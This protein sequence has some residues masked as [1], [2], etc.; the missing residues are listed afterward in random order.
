MIHGGGSGGRRWRVPGAGCVALCALLLAQVAEA[1]S[2]G[3]VDYA[4]TKTVA[5][6]NLVLNGMG[7]REATML[8]VDVYVAG[9]YLEKRS[10]DG[11]AIARSDQVKQMVLKLVRDVDAKDMNEAIEAGFKKNAGNNVAKLAPRVEKF[12]KMMPDLH[13]GD[14]VEFTSVPG[15][16]LDIKVNGKSRGQIEG[17]DFASTFFLIWLGSEPP[18]AGLKKGLLGGP[19]D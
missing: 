9:L 11:G 13:E 6:K 7:I 1:K 17:A 5:G 10:S 12:K 14:L 19:C 3:G 15:Q 16:G 18:N 2:C 4:D 8:K